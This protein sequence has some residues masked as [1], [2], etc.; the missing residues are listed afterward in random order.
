MNE[1]TEQNIFLFPSDV[2]CRALDGSAVSRRLGP[3]LVWASD[4]EQAIA[5]LEAKL[6][7]AGPPGWEYDIDPTHI[8]VV[9]AIR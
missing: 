4:R 9:E 8:W 6:V 3:F 5:K 7:A 2:R 1:S